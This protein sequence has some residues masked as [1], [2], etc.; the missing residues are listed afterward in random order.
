MTELRTT[1]D[2]YLKVRRALGFK[3][4][5]EERHLSEFITFLEHEKAAYITSRLTLRWAMQPKCCQPANWGKRYY[6]VRR[7]A[8]Y[9][10]ALDPRTEIAPTGVLTC[11][12]ARRTPHIYTEREILR[13]IEAA[14]RTRNAPKG[15]WGWTFATIFGLLA[16]TGMR[17]AE[18]VNLDREGVDLVE[19]VLT[20]RETK[21]RK[22]RLV[23]IHPSTTKMLRRYARRRDTVFPELKRGS[24]FVS[25]WGKRLTAKHVGK[26]FLAL[27]RKTGLR[28]PIGE[29][30]PHLH[31]LRHNAARRIMPSD[32]LVDGRQSRQVCTGVM[33]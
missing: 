28:G 1:A 7:F 18:S 27:A 17:V 15:L 29:A 11:H 14:K 32:A 2:T 26:K 20:V 30:G 24:F 9:V 13:L 5:A 12:H 21:F 4:K 23:P 19:G 31:D 33:S 3:M 10:Q 6:T 16:V 25:E 8:K 22:S